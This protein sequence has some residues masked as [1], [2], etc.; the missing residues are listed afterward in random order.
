MV[1]QGA[2]RLFN[3][4][5][6]NYKS[7]KCIPKL[8]YV[9]MLHE[10]PKKSYIYSIAFKAF[11]VM[12]ALCICAF[13]RT[14]STTI[15]HPSSVYFVG[16]AFIYNDRTGY[17][18]FSELKKSQAVEKGN[19]D[20]WGAVMGKRFPLWK[21]IR[22]QAGAAIDAGSVIDDTLYYYYTSAV[23][24]SYFHCG[25]VPELQFVLP[26]PAGNSIRPYISIGGGINYTYINER[27]YTLDNSMEILWEGKPYIKK[28]CFSAS[29]MTGAG[30]DLNFSRNLTINIAYSL[31]Y[32]QPVN[33]DIQQ[34]FLLKA[35]KYHEIFYSHKISLAI[36]FEVI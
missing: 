19:I 9:P 31:Q 4:G 7:W 22:I 20:M 35:Q 26:A 10:R 33:Y 25:I 6:C 16:P 21:F 28:G 23:K 29:A 27:T 3:S 12:E 24:Y 15:I 13:G 11:F 30:F 8:F 18:D 5:I 2:E 14:G 32:W 17:Y 36:L 34:D 1:R